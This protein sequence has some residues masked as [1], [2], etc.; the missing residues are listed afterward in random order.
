MFMLESPNKGQSAYDE[1]ALLAKGLTD[2]LGRD[3]IPA[4]QD[5]SGHPLMVLPPFKARLGVDSGQMAVLA[6]GYAP[7]SGYSGHIQTF[8]LAGQT[9]KAW[10]IVDG[11]RTQS[12]IVADALHSDGLFVDYSDE[13]VLNFLGE[14]SFNTTTQ[15]FICDP[16]Y[17]HVGP[18]RQQDP[19]YDTICDLPANGGLVRA[20]GKTFG[21][22][23]NTAYG[24]G[25]YE[26]TYALHPSGALKYVQ[27]FFG[28][29]APVDWDDDPTPDCGLDDDLD[30]EWDD[31]WDDDLD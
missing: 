6:M 7:D 20:D 3:D 9:F 4:L 22:S 25:T 26:A 29:D 17:Y 10:T 21:V 11:E 31:E 2:L 28:D 1:A 5:F 13:V 14:F 23:T 15:L 8:A 24:D 30:D 18:K 16:C 12:L 19:L 27:V